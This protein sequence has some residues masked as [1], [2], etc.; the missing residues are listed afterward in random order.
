MVASTLYSEKTGQSTPDG[1][2]RNHAYAVIDF[3][4]DGPHEYVTLRDPHGPEATREVD[5]ATFSKNFSALSHEL[6]DGENR[7]DFRYR[8]KLTMV[9]G[10][11]LLAA[12]PT[13]RIGNALGRVASGLLGRGTFGEL[14]R[15]GIIGGSIP[16]GFLGGSVLAVN[17]MDSHETTCTSSRLSARMLAAN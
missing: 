12:I 1:F 10:A 14:L 5:L 2:N 7:C 11:G 3:R 8:E 15:G 6:K 13:F 9:F 17:A 16:L 4:A